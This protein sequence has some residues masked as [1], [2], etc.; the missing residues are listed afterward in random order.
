MCKKQGVSNYPR[1]GL[2]LQDCRH[3]QSR[4]LNCSRVR[5]KGMPYSVPMRA[6]GLKGW[7]NCTTGGIPNRSLDVSE[8]SASCP[9][10]FKYTV[11]GETGKKMSDGRATP[12]RARWAWLAFKV[13]KELR[14]VRNH[15][16]TH[17]ERATRSR[18]R[19]KPYEPYAGGVPRP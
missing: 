10:D 18:D 19:F 14:L 1:R 17:E 15:E 16:V 2:I 6:L 11:L 9:K 5:S 4:V 3:R 8:N 12:P 7:R 13:G